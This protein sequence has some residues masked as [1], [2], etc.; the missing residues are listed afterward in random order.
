MLWREKEKQG[1]WMGKS[2]G[3]GV[4]GGFTE[5]VLEQKPE[6]DG[7]ISHIDNWGRAF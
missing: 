7:R 4:P 5:L 1:S 6:G 2:E 3:K